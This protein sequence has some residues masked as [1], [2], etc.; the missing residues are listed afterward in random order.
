MSI[1]VMYS[2][3]PGSVTERHRCASIRT[4]V[5]SLIHWNDAFHVV[6]LSEPSV[7]TKSRETS[8]QS[9]SKSKQHRDSD[10]GR[11]TVREGEDE[12]RDLH[13]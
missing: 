4:L 9:S 8:E 1:R 2:V 3:R 11:Y 10:N 7:V 5:N 13:T 6:L 12:G